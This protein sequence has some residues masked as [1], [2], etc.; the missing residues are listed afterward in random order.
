M[1]RL[2]PDQ[3]QH[4]RIARMSGM[5]GLPPGTGNALPTDPRLARFLAACADLG[6][7]DRVAAMRG[8]A[9]NT[10]GHWIVPLPHGQSAAPVTH[11]VEIQLLGVCGRGQSLREAVDDWTL[12]A[13]AMCEGAAA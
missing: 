7:A 1:T 6:F 13:V 5:S 3:T 10:G 8:L 4:D 11:L 12:A 2:S 9:E